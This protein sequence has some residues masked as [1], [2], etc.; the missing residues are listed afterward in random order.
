MIGKNRNGVS[1]NESMTVVKSV[2]DLLSEIEYAMAAF[3][4]GNN[5]FEEMLDRIQKLINFARKEL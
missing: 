2:M 4:S 3:E 1:N 5:T